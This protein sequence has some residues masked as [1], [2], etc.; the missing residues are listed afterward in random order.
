MTIYLFR[1]HE[2]IDNRHKTLGSI[3]REPV[4]GTAEVIFLSSPDMMREMFLYE[5]KYPKH[6]L[7]D[8]WTLYNEIHNC[9]R[10]LFFM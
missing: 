1:F 10:G 4:G 6:P 5:G 7:P 8:A 3:F 2:Y 9:K